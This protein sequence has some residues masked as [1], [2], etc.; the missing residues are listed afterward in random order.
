MKRSTI[1][2]GLLLMVVGAGWNV[3]GPAEC[4][5][6]AALVLT[7]HFVLSGSGRNVCLGLLSIRIALL[8]V[9]WYIVDF[10]ISAGLLLCRQLLLLSIGTL[11]L[12]E[13]LRLPPEASDSPPSVRGPLLAGCGLLVVALGGIGGYLITDS[14]QYLIVTGIAVLAHCVFLVAGI[15]RR[16]GGDALSYPVVF[17]AIGAPTVQLLPDTRDLNSIWVMERRAQSLTV[18]RWRDKRPSIDVAFECLCHKD[19]VVRGIAIGRIDFEISEEFDFAFDEFGVGLDRTGNE[20]WWQ[21]SWHE[22]KWPTPPITRRALPLF[23]DLLNNGTRLDRMN[24]AFGIECAGPK[25]MPGLEG[26][27]DLLHE[28][29]DV[30][31]SRVPQDSNSELAGLFQVQTLMAREFENG[32]EPGKVRKRVAEALGSI[33][34]GAVEAVPELTLLL[35][36]IGWPIR[37]AAADALAR[38][39]PPARAAIPALEQA[40]NDELSGDQARVAAASA[41]WWIDRNHPLV[42]PTFRNILTKGPALQAWMDGQV[43]AVNALGRMGPHVADCAVESLLLLLEHESQELR[44]DA[45]RSLCWI[46]G[47]SAQVVEAVAHLGELQENKEI[48]AGYR[49]DSGMLRLFQTVRGP[50]AEALAAVIRDGDREFVRRLLLIF[51]NASKDSD[52]LVMEAI[53]KVELPAQ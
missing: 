53:R 49:F 40:A 18:P 51:R 12:K 44:S 4:L 7:T 22:A 21:H 32:F 9:D 14:V 39:G 41:L 25:G 28:H 5:A 45:F 3:I 2:T 52:P 27:L 23:I 35:Q 6:T 8:W 20:N 11:L 13:L 26:L 16:S 29:G 30:E 17:L 19:S 15:W 1:G 24:A 33:G 43:A 37:V 50:G 48:V 42:E 47:E 46:G 34:P 10:W 38:I 36:D 31:N